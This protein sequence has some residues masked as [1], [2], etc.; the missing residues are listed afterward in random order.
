MC[1][2][3]GARRKKPP[4]PLS[5]YDSVRAYIAHE[6]ELVNY[7]TTWML[8]INGF[9]FAALGLILPKLLDETSKPSL[10]LGAI[11]L[12]LVF[13]GMLCLIGLVASFTSCNALSAAYE[14]T[15]AIKTICKKK[16]ASSAMIGA[17]GLI[18]EVVHTVDGVLPMVTRGGVRRSERSTRFVR[19][20][21]TW[22]FIGL[23]GI[24]AVATWL[25]PRTETGLRQFFGNVSSLETPAPSH[26]SAR[27]RRPSSHA[28]SRTGTGGPSVPPPP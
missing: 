23:W 15:L 25:C 4:I 26:D 14:S 24:I 3:Q 17:G 2:S 18:Y 9:L 13:I 11:T 19:F 12:Y 7:R 5:L 27:D 10:N 8:T 21:L 28:P 20:G 6:D 16:Y 22:L 1:Q